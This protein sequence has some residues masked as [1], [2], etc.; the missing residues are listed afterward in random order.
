MSACF[1]GSILCLACFALPVGMWQRHFFAHGAWVWLI[2]RVEACR[3][4]QQTHKKE[5]QNEAF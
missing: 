3:N 2:L 1:L 4:L 5:G